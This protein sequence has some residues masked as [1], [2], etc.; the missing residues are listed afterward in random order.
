MRQVQSN[1]PQLFIDPAV[2]VGSFLLLLLN[3]V[4]DILRFSRRDG[5]DPL[6]VVYIGFDKEGD[7]FL[8]LERRV[9]GCQ[10][11]EGFGDWIGVLIEQEFVSH[12]ATVKMHRVFAR[13]NV[14]P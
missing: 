9:E 6:Y 1:T 3:D 7:V 4:L 11:W 2:L 5:D 14:E 13:C 10:C 12:A 8:E